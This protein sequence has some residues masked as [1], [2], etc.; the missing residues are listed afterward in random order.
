[1]KISIQ[2]LDDAFHFLANNEAGNTV[3]MDTSP[4]NG[5]SGQGAGPMQLLVMALGGC[6]GI[7]IV[8]ILKKSRQPLE[9][10]NIEVE[11]ERAKGQVPALFTNIHVHYQL[12]GNLD[13][14]K[15]RR[16][17]TLSLDKYCSVANILEKTAQITA[18]FSV[19]GTR[20]E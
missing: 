7:D 3:H 16:A 2:R 8:D 4:A 15:V 19:N 20:Y 14:N 9:D 1:M 10:I 5:G 17:V 12:T 6:S 18:S 13:V 11:Y